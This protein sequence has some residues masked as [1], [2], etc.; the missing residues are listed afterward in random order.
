MEKMR[1]KAGGISPHRA[2]GAPEDT[3]GLRLVASGSER[4]AVSRADDDLFEFDVLFDRGG[5]AAKV[6]RRR[7]G[8]PTISLR[9]AL[10]RHLRVGP[11]RRSQMVGS[12]RRSGPKLQARLRLVDLLVGEKRRLPGRRRSFRARRVVLQRRVR[13]KSRTPTARHPYHLSSMGAAAP[14]A[15]WA[16]PSFPK[17]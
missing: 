10:P 12:A 6:G 11:P 5:C 9:W 1:P 8:I 13:R 14:S 3:R 15:R 4:G 2:Q 17:W 7:R 16:S